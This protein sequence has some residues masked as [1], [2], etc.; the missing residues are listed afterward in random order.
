[1]KSLDQ[2]LYPGAVLV[3]HWGGALAK[4]A[5]V[6]SKD[7]GT[8]LEIESVLTLDG[9]LDRQYVG[10]GS[11]ALRLIRDMAIWRV[12]NLFWLSEFD[13]RLNEVQ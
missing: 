13:T 12:N 6:Q 1:V 4:E 11:L 3:C 9:L 8:E 7:G 2:Q 10:D 5:V